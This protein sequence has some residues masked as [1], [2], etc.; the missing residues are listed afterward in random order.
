VVDEQFHCRQG[1]AW[2]PDFDPS[3][4]PIDLSSACRVYG[5]PPI[6]PL[7]VT[8]AAPSGGISLAAMEIWINRR[9]T[10]TM[11]AV[12]KAW[13]LSF[14]AHATQAQLWA[15]APFAL[16]DQ[17]HGQKA[18]NVIYGTVGDAE[19]VLMDYQFTTGDG[20]SARTSQATAVILPDGPTGLPDFQIAP[21]TFLDKVLGFFTPRGLELADADAF[22]RRCL[23]TGPL[24]GP[25]RR[26]FPPGVSAFFG[27]QGKLFV[28]S[29]HGHLLIYRNR[30]VRPEQ[31]RVLATEALEI[32]AVLEGAAV[33]NEACPMPAQ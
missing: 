12:G 27:R 20:R 11:A 9:R 24:E 14:T 16:F 25:I 10:A 18:Y 2:T 7:D 8:D 30:Q 15:I 31:C 1:H 13:G 32:G 33:R 5:E 6:S 23:L 28:E 29:L 3:L 26:A 4:R 19:V 21:R 22:N 17:G